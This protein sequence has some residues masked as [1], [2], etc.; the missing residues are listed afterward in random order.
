MKTV[1]RFGTSILAAGI[2][3]GSPAALF[4]VD[5]P[6]TQP[7]P[8]S[9]V[10]METQGDARVREAISSIEK[11]PDPSAVVEAYAKATEKDSVPLKQAYVKRLVTLGVPE[12][13]ETQARDLSR[14]GPEDGLAW[15]VVAFMD[16]R[17]NNTPAALKDIVTAA[18]RLPEDPFVE[19]TA[20]QI[21]AYYEVYADRNKIDGALRDSV[22]QTRQ[23]L[24]AKPTFAQAYQQAKQSYAQAAARL[25]PPAA[26]GPA[27]AVVPEPYSVVQPESYWVSPTTV[28][29]NTYNTYPDPYAYDAYSSNPWWP[30][31]WW[32]DPGVVIVDGPFFRD[33][34]RFGH[35]FDDRDHRF[36]GRSDR[37]FEDRRDGE[38]DR[39]GRSSDERGFRGGSGETRGMPPARSMPFRSF[40]PSRSSGGFSG[41]GGGRSFGSPMG[42][43]GEV[44]VDTAAVAAVAAGIADCFR[45]PPAT[46]RRGGMMPCDGRW[47]GNHPGHPSH[48]T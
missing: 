1:S 31:A 24:S 21:I 46:M 42:G 11:A 8:E 2:L 37:G 14:R 40:G 47:S 28:Y 33:R 23:A 7:A 19:R 39:G 20:A 41:G 30:S 29:N 44:A 27:Q 4:A 18:G 17:R 6:P 38:S 15:A 25:M 10:V 26:T 34:D 36:E 16:A 12:L 43:G 35:D 45:P 32:W 22:E 5:P 3:A 48:T 13:A 9:K